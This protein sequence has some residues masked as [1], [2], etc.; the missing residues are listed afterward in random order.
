LS[1]RRWQSG[2]PRPAGGVA[3]PFACH[4]GRE[5][6]ARGHVQSDLFLWHRYY[7]RTP[8]QRLA[9]FGERP[10]P[11]ETDEAGAIARP[12][13]GMVAVPE[14]D[15]SRYRV[16]EDFGR[17]LLASFGRRYLSA[18]GTTRCFRFTSTSWK[19]SRLT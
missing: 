6:G 17:K 7:I 4:H 13:S 8:W 12:D 10:R 5:P 3:G 14:F 11:A 16:A 18:S 19:A 9:A 1:V 15:R 2:C